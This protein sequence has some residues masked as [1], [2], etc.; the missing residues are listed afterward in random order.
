MSSK[1]FSNVCSSG[2]TDFSVNPSENLLGTLCSQNRK[3]FYYWINLDNPKKYFD[4]ATNTSLNA[5]ATR[6]FINN[7]TTYE[8]YPLY[9]KNDAIMSRSLFS[10]SVYNLNSRN[11]G[12]NISP[13]KKIIVLWDTYSNVYIYNSSNFALMHTFTPNNTPSSLSTQKINFN[14]KSTL[15]A[16]ETD[17]SNPII[18]LNLSSFAVKQ[19][20]NYSQKIVDIQFI[21]SSDQFLHI[22]G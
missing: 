2:M 6:I 13:N 10:S 7:Y 12:I 9:S 18:I 19:S 8:F 16:I 22:V 15:I 21:D 5:K 14:S 17:T 20:I 4:S 11:V 1:N 3:V